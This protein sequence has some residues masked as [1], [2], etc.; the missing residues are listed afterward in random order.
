MCLLKVPAARMPDCSSMASAES[1][2]I[3][4]IPESPFLLPVRK[5]AIGPSPGRE[6]SNTDKRLSD[7]AR[8]R[9]PSAVNSREWGEMNASVVGFTRGYDATS[10]GVKAELRRIG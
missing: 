9:E 5:E 10:S 7:P 6:R 1:I 8:N 2:P 4:L 3:I